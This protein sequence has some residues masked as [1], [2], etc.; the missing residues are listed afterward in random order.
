MTF[1]GLEL[2]IGHREGG[3]AG[4]CF[5]LQMNLQ[6]MNVS[7]R[8]LGLVLNFKSGM[9]ILGNGAILTHPQTPL[10][11][12]IC[13]CDS[14]SVACLPPPSAISRTR[15]K[16]RR[17]RQASYFCTRS[18]GSRRLLQSSLDYAEIIEIV[19]AASIIHCI[20][21]ESDYDSIS[22]LLPCSDCLLRRFLL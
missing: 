2:G 7:R 18:S 8:T 1:G 11:R 16:S 22:S 10:A 13:F 15:L 21:A 3:C 9:N 19:I 14:L 12:P 6:L 17:D 20:Q 4:T 5:N